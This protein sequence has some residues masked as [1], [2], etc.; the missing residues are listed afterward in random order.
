M[1]VSVRLLADDSYPN[2]YIQHEYRQGGEIIVTDKKYESDLPLSFFIKPNPLEESDVVYF[3][4]GYSWQNVKSNSL[5]SANIVTS[6]PMVNSILSLWKENNKLFVTII[7]STMNMSTIAEL[8]GVMYSY[9]IIDAKWLGKISENE[10]LLLV[11][12]TLFICSVNNNKD[13]SIKYIA[14]DIINAV[15]MYDPGSDKHTYKFA[16]L[17]FRDGSGVVNFLMQD[18]TEKFSCRINV[19]DDILLRKFNNRI[20]V[21][22]T[23]K[24]V[25]NSKVFIIDPERGVVSEIELESAADRII[26]GI[27]DYGQYIYYL[28][29]E[30]DF[31]SLRYFAVLDS[32][33]SKPAS[34]ERS[35]DIPKELIEP[36]CLNVVGN[37][38]YAVFRNG[39]ATFDLD[40][41][42]ISVDFF[43][44]GEYFG[45]PPNIRVN[46]DYLLLTTNSASFVLVKQQ[47]NFWLF[48][49]FI[50]NFGKILFPFILMV[51]I[52]ISE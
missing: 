32:T 15:S 42:L 34:K 25:P 40:G 7:D 10:Y 35:T 29:N 49:R 44:F 47:H 31:Y 41:S 6:Y 2:S 3:W 19:Y 22:I 28:K 26:T 14:N 5:G 18:N 45:K 50:K 4:H 43:P 37:S 48:S 21:I 39:L 1:L 38:I 23:P 16:Y 27:E 17:V 36:L 13:I 46:A 12:N 24:S 52:I 30:K 33:K 20:A 9:Y 51:I 8:T 11:N